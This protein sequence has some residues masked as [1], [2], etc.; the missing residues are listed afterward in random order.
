[1]KSDITR[2]EIKSL[3]SNLMS[4]DE[5][6]KKDRG[7]KTVEDFRMNALKNQFYSMQRIDLLVIS[8]STGG[9]ALVLS[10]LKDLSPTES[11]LSIIGYIS[12]ILFFLSILTNLGSQITAHKAHANDAEWA[13]E[14]IQFLNGV[15]KD[16]AED[17]PVLYDN[18]TMI[19]NGISIW[20]LITS[21]ILIIVMLGCAI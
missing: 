7:Y 11:C 15:S 9:I 2:E 8:L 12:V 16:D 14:R 21:V 5:E 17:T 10:Y 18:L 6:K 20:S 19:F 13:R 3:S 4:Q 1:M